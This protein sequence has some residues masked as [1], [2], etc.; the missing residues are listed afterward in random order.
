MFF[1]ATLLFVATALLWT[2]CSSSSSTSAR[3]VHALPTVSGTTLDF[4]VDG[5]SVATG[6]TY[7]TASNYV[8]VSSGS[9]HLQAEL[10]NST[11]IVADVTPSIS[12]GSFTT[13]ISFLDS[14]NASNVLVLTDNNSA[15]PSGD[16]NLR[17]INLCPAVG[18]QDV[19]IV[20]PGTS[21]SSTTATFTNLA[22]GGASSY[23]S[24]AAGDWEVI[25][26]VPG[27]PFNI[28]GDSGTLSFSS[29]QVRTLLFLNNPGGGVETQLLTD[30][31]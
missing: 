14:T 1:G 31:H 13:M 22:V 20:P 12:S 6:I 3:L 16:F 7:G 11:T 19:Y 9:R 25:F 4:L 18:A 24:N 30:A 5:S 15:P 10:S 17:V 28:G 8:K 2:A 23:S 26:T 27:Q 29:G 21:P